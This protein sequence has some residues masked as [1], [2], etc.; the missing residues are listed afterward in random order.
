MRRPV[1]PRA[2]LAHLDGRYPD[3]MAPVENQPPVVLF[4]CVSN[5]GKSRMA[6][7]IMRAQVGDAIEVH[8]AG[9]DPAASGRNEESAAA[10]A[11]IGVDMGD[12]D[13][14][15]IDDGLLARADRVVLLGTDA[16]LDDAEIPGIV[17]RWLTVEPSH[18]GIE[19]AERMRLIRDDIASRTQALADELLA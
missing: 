2:N 14:R 11:E 12:A 3:A 15:G 4:V 6:E 1:V 10:L 13:P 7:S 9:T 17:A 16:R 19:G 18:D 5:K 8:S